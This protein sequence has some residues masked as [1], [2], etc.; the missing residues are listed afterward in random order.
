VKSQEVPEPLSPFGSGTLGLP[1]GNFQAGFRIVAESRYGA[2]SSTYLNSEQAALIV[3]FKL[4]KK[5]GVRQ[6]GPDRL[7]GAITLQVP[8][9]RNSYVRWFLQDRWGED[10]T[11]DAEAIACA[12]EEHWQLLY[13]ACVG[14]LAAIWPR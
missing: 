2:M 14:A 9:L 4:V 13:Y 7:R 10:L 8:A 3:S 1:A 6:G 12:R 5:A 11:H